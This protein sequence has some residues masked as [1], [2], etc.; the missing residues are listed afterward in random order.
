MEA[1]ATEAAEEETANGG[2]EEEAAE[3]SFKIWLFTV[4]SILVV[5]NEREKVLENNFLAV[6]L[7]KFYSKLYK[8]FQM[9]T[10]LEAL[11]KYI[12]MSSH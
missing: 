9:K 12:C 5:V 3:E 8:M 7:L 2:A 11:K 6:K 10:Y 1:E 4:D